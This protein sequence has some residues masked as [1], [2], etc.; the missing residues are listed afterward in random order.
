MMIKKEKGRRKK[1][2]KKERDKEDSPLRKPLFTTAIMQ[3]LHQLQSSN[4]ICCW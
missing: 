4:H 2:K 1:E 3:P